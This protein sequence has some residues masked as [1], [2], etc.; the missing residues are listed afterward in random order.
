[1]DALSEKEAFERRVFP[2]ELIIDVVG[3]TEGS[4]ETIPK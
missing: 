4:K 3:R 1:M 2:S